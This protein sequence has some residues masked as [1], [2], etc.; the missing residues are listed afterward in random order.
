LL[1][2]E[3]RAGADAARDTPASDNRKGAMDLTYQSVRYDPASL[4]AWQ[5]GRY[6]W[7]K[8]SG[9]SEFIV[10]IL[11]EKAKRRAAGRIRHG[12]PRDRRF[13]GEAFVA[14]QPAFKHRAGWYGSFKWLSNAS[15]CHAPLRL[16]RGYRG[17]FLNALHDHVHDLNETQSKQALL[18]PM[19]GDRRA[20]PPDL[21]LYTGQKHRFIEV[22]LP[23]DRVRDAQLAGL[24]LIATCLKTKR[25]LSVE[26]VDLVED[27]RD[28]GKLS[29]A[30][31]EMFRSFC[32][33]LT[34][35]W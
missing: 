3:H 14:A 11:T 5:A 18:R 29:E 1:G 9:A 32:D 27:N 23:G 16:G 22:K 26:I 34:A 24:A 7:L 2:S 25:P 12:R 4:R 17:E 20:V 15:W 30:E 31:R 13:F 35:S 8:Q 19:L 10:R 6:G 21:W 28:A 33:T